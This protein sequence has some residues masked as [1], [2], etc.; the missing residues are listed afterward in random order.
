MAIFKESKRERGDLLNAIITLAGSGEEA[1]FPSVYGNKAYDHRAVLCLL[2]L[3]MS[4]VSLS[5]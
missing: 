4:T 3:I 5:T 1:H 2:T